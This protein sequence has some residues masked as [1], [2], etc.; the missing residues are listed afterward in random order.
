MSISDSI[1]A[2]RT[3]ISS[4]HEHAYLSEQFDSVIAKLGDLTAAYKN[5]ETRNYVGLYSRYETDLHTILY[6]ALADNPEEQPHSADRAA[7]LVAQYKE[8]AGFVESKALI[9]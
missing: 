3:K 2:L 4:G 9:R 8:D 1:A 5:G 6:R 7:N